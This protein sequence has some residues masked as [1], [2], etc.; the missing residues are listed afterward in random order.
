MVL[1][2]WSEECSC[3]NERERPW[4]Y[5]DSIDPAPL[6]S[7]FTLQYFLSITERSIKKEQLG[8]RRRSDQTE[9][10]APLPHDLCSTLFEKFLSICFYSF[11]QLPSIIPAS[12]V[13]SLW[14]SLNSRCN[15]LGSP[16]ILER[17]NL[18]VGSLP[19]ATVDLFVLSLERFRFSVICLQTLK[20][21]GISVT[22]NVL[23]K[24]FHW[25]LSRKFPENT[26]RRSRS[27][28]KCPTLIELSPLSRVL[29]K[30]VYS[31]NPLSNPGG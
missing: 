20:L 1:F 11:F 15:T 16:V 30:I 6:L 22:T 4:R 9:K 26:I 29:S 2:D 23:E 19:F 8:E 25:E 24:Y 14:Q 10:L 13:P 7:S 21:F 28:P 18:P 27:V 12:S 5:I 17:Q 31:S 3:W